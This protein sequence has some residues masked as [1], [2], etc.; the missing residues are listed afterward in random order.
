MVH[1]NAV[2]PGPNRPPL[3]PPQT[4]KWLLAGF[5]AVLALLFL[6]DGLYHRHAIFPWEEWFGFYAVFGFVA[7]VM[8][9]LVAKHL[10]RPIV[11]RDEDY[12]DR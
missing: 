6:A 12:Y 3:I 9:V 7:C 5:Y 1:H 4:L 8:L 2:N 11:M 10:L